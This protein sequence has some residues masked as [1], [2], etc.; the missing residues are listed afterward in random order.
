[1]QVVILYESLTGTTKA[2]ARLIADEFYERDVASKI[3]PVDGYDPDAI[4]EADVVIA[5]TWTDG[6]VLL[7]QKPAK[8]KKFAKLPDL[9]GKRS[10]VFCTYAV[11]P[12]KTLTKF[13]TVL[14]ERGAEVLGGFAIKRNQLEQGAADFVERVMD[15][16]TV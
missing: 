10:V 11:D 13:T 1:M 8:R 3:Y 7:G 12:G 14:E 16:A 9:A 4:T 2:A 5:G 15:V 6:L